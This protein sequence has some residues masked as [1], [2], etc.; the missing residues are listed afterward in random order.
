M[1]KLVIQGGFFGVT[2]LLIVW[3]T[4]TGHP[5]LMETLDKLSATTE[6]QRK[7]NQALVESLQNKFLAAIDAQQNRFIELLQKMDE[8]GEREQAAC[9]E[10]RK[11]QTKAFQTSISELL[12]RVFEG[13]GQDNGEEPP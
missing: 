11:Q 10:E 1:A 9:R 4:R 5:R 8:R 13:K 2:I 12:A 6:L 3:W 7:E